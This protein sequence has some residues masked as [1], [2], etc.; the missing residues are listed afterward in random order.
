MRKRFHARNEKQ[1]SLNPSRSGALSTIT[2]RLAAFI[3][4]ENAY[5]RSRLLKQG[6][7]ML[8]RRRSKSL[9]TELT[10]FAQ[11][12]PGQASALPSG[13]GAAGYAQEGA[14]GG[15]RG[16][17]RPVAQLAGTAVAEVARNMGGDPD[18]GPY[19]HAMLIKINISKHIIPTFQ[20]PDGASIA[21]CA[22]RSESHHEP[23]RSLRAQGCASCHA[24]R[25]IG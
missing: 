16:P 23:M 9:G 2:A 18:Q 5:L 22:R 7:A 12:T 17:Y 19:S 6:A 20:N 14:P 13:I 11:E 24:P 4:D 10:T 25:D 8:K 15:N 21:D 3:G 1:R